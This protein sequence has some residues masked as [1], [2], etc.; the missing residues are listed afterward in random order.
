MQKKSNSPDEGK[1]IA[2]SKALI[3][4]LRD[5]FQKHPLITPNT[6][7]E[8][9]TFDSIEIYNYLLEE[10]SFEKAYIPLNGRIS[11][12]KADRLLNEN[13][14]SCCPK[15]SSLPMKREASKF[16]LRCGLPTM[17]FVYP[18]MK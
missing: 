6:F 13:G 4:V 14:I 11:L 3:P 10:T 15:D 2:D 12:P 17:K 8:D 5:F 9:A 18:K 1:S 16:H 7:L